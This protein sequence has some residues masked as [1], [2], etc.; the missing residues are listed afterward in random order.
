MYLAYKVKQELHHISIVILGST[1]I[2]WL[3]NTLKIGVV[4]WLSLLILESCL[5]FRCI[6][7]IKE[8]SLTDRPAVF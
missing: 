1:I 3:Q 8:M 7:P 6:H 4:K 2:S 5:D